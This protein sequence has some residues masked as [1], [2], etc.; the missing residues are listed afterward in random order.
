VSIISD[1]FHLPD[2]VV[3]VI[4]RAKGLERL[5]LVSD[6]ALFGGY[7]PGVYSWEGRSIEVYRDGHLGLPGTSI[8]AGAA[9]LLDWDIPR[10]ME[11]TGLGLSE[12]VRLCTQNPARI[13][14]MPEGY[15]KLKEGSPANLCLLRYRSGD[16]RLSIE[17]TICCGVE[18][19]VGASSEEF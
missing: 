12:A 19:F 17:R 8:L 13:M 2:Y 3:K 15:G 5:I 14:K 1:G 10:F 7:S 6:A 4:S 11:F 18:I 16:A 9:H